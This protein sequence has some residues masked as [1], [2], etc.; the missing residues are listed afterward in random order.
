MEPHFPI[1]V[2]NPLPSDPRFRDDLIWLSR[3][4][5]SYAQTW[6]TRLEI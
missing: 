3:E 6:K 1:P 2:P 5:E 4:N